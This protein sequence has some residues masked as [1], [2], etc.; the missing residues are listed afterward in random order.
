VGRNSSVAAIGISESREIAGWFDDA[1]ILW[2]GYLCREAR[3][4][5][6]I[7]RLQP[8]GQRMRGWSRSGGKLRYLDFRPGNSKG[9]IGVIVGF[10]TDANKRVSPHRFA[11]E[12]GEGRFLDSGFCP[13]CQQLQKEGSFTPEAYPWVNEPDCVNVPIIN[14]LRGYALACC[15]VSSACCGGGW[16]RTETSFETP[17]SCMVTP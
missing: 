17:G 12:I 15:R 6:L 1:Q 2:N 5:E 16:K 10:Y 13:Y 9:E 3:D 8:A 11:P 14:C 7:G 4:G